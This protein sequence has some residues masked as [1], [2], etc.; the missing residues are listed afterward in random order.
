MPD[1]SP[2]P[3]ASDYDGPPANNAGSAGAPH[4][5]EAEL[6]ASGWTDK[7]IA[8]SAKKPQDSRDD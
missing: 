6:R 5:T 2:E 3:S 8:E 4:P 7:Q 1:D